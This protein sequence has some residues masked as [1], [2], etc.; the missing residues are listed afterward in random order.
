MKIEES[1]I[2]KLDNPLRVGH[3]QSDYPLKP[4]KSFFRIDMLDLDLGVP[5][6]N[7]WI[8]LNS[9]GSKPNLNR[10]LFGR[11]LSDLLKE[12][13][14]DTIE[15]GIKFPENFVNDRKHRAVYISNNNNEIVEELLTIP[16]EGL[17][18]VVVVSTTLRYYQ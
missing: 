13:E 14:G 4:R 6:W 3:I 11:F 17:F 9:K 7:S 15:C 2:L 8:G 12:K 18:S 5:G 16:E 1:N 10:G